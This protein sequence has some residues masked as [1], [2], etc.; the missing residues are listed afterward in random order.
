MPGKPHG[1]GRPPSYRMGEMNAATTEPALGL[2]LIGLGRPWGVRFTA[3]PTEAQVDDLLTAALELGITFW[4]TAASYGA[5]EQRIGRFLKSRPESRVVV[6]TK[7]GDHW[8]PGEAESRIDHSYDALRRSFDRSRERL[9]RIDILQV[10]R[11]SVDAL[12]D[13]GTLRALEY[14][15]G[16]GV[17]ELGAS[18]K[19]LAAARQALDCGLFQWLQMPY[20]RKNAAMEPVFAWA[21]EKQVKV[22]VNRPFAEGALV[23]GGGV[24]AAFRFIRAQR[25]DGVVIVGTASAAHLRENARNYAARP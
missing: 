22:I 14:A 3:L 11:A 2:G 24:E 9:G 13:E 5:S 8:E 23:E 1:E 12:S 19:D 6:A 7:F 17:A 15:R 25:F 21:A 18:V 20:N 4:D 10:H 16:Q